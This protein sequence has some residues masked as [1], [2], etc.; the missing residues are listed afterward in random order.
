MRLAGQPKQID[1]NIRVVYLTGTVDVWVYVGLKRTDP[2]GTYYFPVDYYISLGPG[3]EYTATFTWYED[4]FPRDTTNPVTG[5]LGTGVM[6]EGNWTISLVVQ[7]SGV[8]GGEVEDSDLTNNIAD[9]AH[10]IVAKEWLVDIDGSGQINILD[11]AAAAT[12]FGS[13]PGHERW[14]PAAD[15]NGDNKVDIL[16]IAAI[17]LQ[18]GA[19]FA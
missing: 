18:F 11:I 14:N 5:E 4:G 9:E 16:D 17:A 3:E 7:P 19:T 15:I 10:V 12:A 6:E 8:P 1:Y 2:S 13:V